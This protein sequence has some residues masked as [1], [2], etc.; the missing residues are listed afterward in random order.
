MARTL[1]NDS[2]F[3][4]I[5]WT[6]V[7]HTFSHILNRAQIRIGVNM[8]PYELWK[9][10]PS[11]VNNFWIFGSKGYIK[12]NEDN[13]GKFDSRSGEGYFLGYVARSKAYICYNISIKNII[14][15]LM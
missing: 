3:L 11:I 14:E 13:L 9:G 7:V 8:T 1:L 4:Y 6:H 2:K 15:I 12:R 10:R 5:F